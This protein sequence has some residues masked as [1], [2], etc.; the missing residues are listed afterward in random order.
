[1]FSFGP[2][3]STKRR[4]GDSEQMASGGR[5][6]TVP[7]AAHHGGAEDAGREGDDKGIGGKG[8]GDRAK[9]LAR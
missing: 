1:M 3:A 6:A 2:M 5:E 8:M 4:A 7:E 9:R